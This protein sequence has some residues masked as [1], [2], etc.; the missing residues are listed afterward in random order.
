MDCLE[1]TI[2]IYIVNYH[3]LSNQLQKENVI[4][5][6]TDHHLKHI[7]ELQ[8]STH[9]QTNRNITKPSSSTTIPSHLEL[10]TKP[11]NPYQ[12]N[13]SRRH[14]YEPNYKRNYHCR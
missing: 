2:V 6:Q 4:K 10:Q 3:Q 5:L 7:A 12:T 11:Q 14:H 1:S 13:H 8:T 9:Q